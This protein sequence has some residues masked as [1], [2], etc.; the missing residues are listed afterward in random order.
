VE[1]YRADGEFT[2]PSDVAVDH[3]GN[4]MADANNHVIRKISTAGAVTTLAGNGTVQVSQRT[5]LAA[6][7]HFP[8]WPST[9]EDNIYIAINL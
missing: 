9:R 3:L 2:R 7:F 1:W 5:S 4:S 6:Q 8:A